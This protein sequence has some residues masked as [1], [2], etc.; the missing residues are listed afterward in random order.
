MSR[1]NMVERHVKEVVPSKRTL[2]ALAAAPR[3][4][5]WVEEIRN[6]KRTKLPKDPATGRNASVPTEPST[7]GTRAAAEKRWRR[8]KSQTDDP[9]GV[10]IVLGELPGTDHFL[11]GI[12]LDGCIDPQQG[13]VADWAQEVIA[14]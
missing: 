6:N 10:G 8:I 12:D 2:D 11:L 1:D 4:V 14:R 3:W 13:E 7:W 5:A 9:S